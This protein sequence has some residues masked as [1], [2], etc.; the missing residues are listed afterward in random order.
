MLRTQCRIEPKPVVED[1]RGGGSVAPAGAEGLRRT[2]EG[3][4]EAEDG[5]GLW[6]GICLGQGVG[7]PAFVF[8][9]D[10]T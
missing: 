3:V 7:V 4:A 5:C 6:P 8:S 2:S 1:E 9:E 10:S